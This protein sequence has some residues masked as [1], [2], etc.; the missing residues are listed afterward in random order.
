MKNIF[1]AGMHTD[2]GK[3]HASAVLCASF[4]YE[5]FKLIQAGAPGDSEFIASF[6]QKFCDNELKAIKIH[7]CGLNLAHACSPHAGMIKENLNINALEI[8]LPKNENLLIELAGGLF[9]PLDREHFMIDYVAKYDFGVFLVACE[10]L[11]SIN[12]TALSIE[13]LKARNINLLGVIFS[14]CTDELSKDFLKK[15]YNHIKFFELLYFD[16]EK[17]LKNACI[18]LKEQILISGVLDDLPR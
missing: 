18:S 1:L 16:D 11:G 17:S 3:T 9:T 10:Y 7:N 2:A 5:Y 15:H 8:S 12:H 4:G 14:N 6:S 13:A